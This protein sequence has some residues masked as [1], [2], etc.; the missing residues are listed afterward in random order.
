MS[1]DFLTSSLFNFLAK[2]HISIPKVVTIHRWISLVYNLSEADTHLE[3]ELQIRP[4][5]RRDLDFF[6]HL[7]DLRDPSNHILKQDIKFWYQYGFKCLNVGY[8]KDITR[9]CCM[10][11]WINDSDNHRFKNMEYGAMYQR[12]NTETIHGEGGYVLKSMRGRGLF[13]KFRITMH[14][15]LFLKGKKVVRAH[16]ASQKGRLPSLKVAASVG[17]V[18]D[19]WISMV[20][21]QLPLCKSNVFVH[22]PIKDS[23]RNKF[24][25]NLFKQNDSTI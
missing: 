10:Q 8:L 21:T 5:E 13:R 6:S 2:R 20:R 4:G 19:H 3:S 24:P 17:F 14:K 7:G 22:H 16:I 15:I 11:F 1:D 18:A 9:P 25:L 12:L 23:E